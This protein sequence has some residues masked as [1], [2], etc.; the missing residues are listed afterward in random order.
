MLVVLRATEVVG[1]ASLPRQCCEN[2][3]DSRKRLKGGHC[4]LGEGV[5]D[6]AETRCDQKEVH[7]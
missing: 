5:E 6:I 1:S 4:E 3:S 2:L 7:E